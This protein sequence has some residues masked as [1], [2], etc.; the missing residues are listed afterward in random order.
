VNILKSP[1]FIVAPMVDQSFI[2]FRTLCRRYG[3]QLCY[4]PM[5]HSKNFARDPVYRQKF[6]ST[7][8]EDRPLVVQF[9]SN[10]PAVLLQA[11]KFVEKQ[12]DAVDINL[13]C[14]QNI[15]KRG[16]YGA[17]LMESPDLVYQ[18]VNV[19]HKHLSVPVFCKMR[20]LPDIEETV[21]F[22]KMLQDAGCQLLTV[23]GRTKEQKGRVQ[24]LADWNTIKRIKEELN[25]PIFANGNI[26]E[27]S[28]VL[29]CLHETKTDGVMSAEGILK[30][31]ALFSG[32]I[33]DACDIANEYL[34][35]CEHT[36]PTSY[37]YIR[38]HLLQILK[39]RLDIY[40]DLRISISRTRT[41]PEARK[42]IEEITERVLN[43]APPVLWEANI[44]EQRKDKKINKTE[45]SWENSI[46]EGA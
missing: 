4:T 37:K 19:L 25:I 23:H 33:V 45:E 16:N 41:I 22:A 40:A 27:F 11:A 24:G 3:A 42:V 1:K 2:A 15:A 13:G 7:A 31:P 9:C 36:Y 14:P 39:S 35:L 17:F 21:K 32:R 26:Q 8:P 12:C 38:T 46:F 5:M 44:R 20:I 18:L 10:E 29:Q 43:N 6:F 30:T 28:D 34:D